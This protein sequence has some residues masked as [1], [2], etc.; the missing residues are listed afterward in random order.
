MTEETFLDREEHVWISV[1]SEEWEIE[2]SIPYQRP[3][4]RL[5]YKEIRKEYLKFLGDEYEAMKKRFNYTDDDM[6][7]EMESG[8]EWQERAMSVASCVEG[9][10]NC[11][12]DHMDTDLNIILLYPDPTITKR[13]D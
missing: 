7:F 12:I 10:W 3:E 13:G 5:R 4:N 11:I 9:K 2:E 1:Y 6:Q 8:E